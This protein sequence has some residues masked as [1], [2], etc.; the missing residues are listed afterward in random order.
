MEIAA[1]VRRFGSRYLNRYLIEEGGRLTLLDAGLS[2]YW[3]GLLGELEAIGRGMEDIDA[4]LLTH[5]HT[6]HLGIA[7]RVR[8]AAGAAVYANAL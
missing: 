3:R 8:I 7:E 5:S 4:V 2:G 6:D 1:G